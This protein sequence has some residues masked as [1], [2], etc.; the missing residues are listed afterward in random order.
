MNIHHLDAEVQEALNAL[1]KYEVMLSSAYY[2]EI[3]WYG[4]DAVA[5]VHVMRKAKE[6]AEGKL[7]TDEF[8]NKYDLN[9][10]ITK[11]TNGTSLVKPCIQ[12]KKVASDGIFMPKHLNCIGGWEDY[13][14]EVRL[15]N[16]D[17]LN[18]V[19]LD[20]WTNKE[21]AKD[22][23]RTSWS[24]DLKDADLIEQG[25]I[26]GKDMWNTCSVGFE[27]WVKELHRIRKNQPQKVTDLGRK[28][29]EY[30]SAIVSE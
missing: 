10:K 15:F 3:V 20:S 30:Y 18:R 25:I 17:Y 24:G 23:V 14:R 29:I 13:S 11:L 16:Y 27:N 5:H 26:F 22:L 19:S 21:Y 28:L 8:V 2:H 9:W 4:L 7:S 1:T 6:V 12:L